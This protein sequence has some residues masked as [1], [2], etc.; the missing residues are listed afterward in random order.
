MSRVAA[1]VCEGCTDFPILEGIILELWPEVD[2]VLPLQPPLDE[3]GRP[4]SIRRGWSAVKTWC[5]SN[6][7]NLH[8][9]LSSDFGDPIDLLVVALDV[10]IAIQ[11]EI[12][13]PP[14]QGLTPYV[15][16]RLC[17][18]VKGWLTTTDRRLP[19]ELVIVLPAMAIEAWIIAAV[20]AK[21]ERP[22]NLAAPAMYLAEH[23]EL[24]LIARQP[25]GD[26]TRST[27]QRPHKDLSR[28]RGRFR[29]TVTRSLGKVRKKCVEAERFCNKVEQRRARTRPSSA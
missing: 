3:L 28:Y 11:A 6:A 1:V 5:E 12:I 22:E 8:Q 15:A 10:D 29:S 4:T 7:E 13:N 25:A 19:A 20:I 27:R 14:R 26:S 23:G 18:T 9:L 21:C 17:N 24:E 2:R 16:K